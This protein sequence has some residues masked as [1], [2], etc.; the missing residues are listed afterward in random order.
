MQYPVRSAQRL[1]ALV[2]QLL[3]D[4]GHGM[5]MLFEAFWFMQFAFGKRSRYETAT[6]LYIT[7][8]KSL[9]VISVVALFTGMILA[10]QT[11]LELRRYGQEVYIGSAVAVSMIRE[12]GPFMT[13]LII[14]ASVGSAIAA[15][16]GTMS[17]SEE[18]SALEVMSI[19]PNRFL[20]MPRL[21]ALTVMMPILTVYTNILGILGGAVVG[22]TQLGVSFDAYVGN[23]TEFATNKDLYV[24]L[25]KAL[26][27]GIII[28]TVSCHQGF[29]T[30]EGAVGVGKA[31]RRS[32]IISFLV[33]L[34]VG[35]MVT[36]LF[37]I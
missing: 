10:L 37:Y 18:I 5:F 1:G 20:V 3:H 21:V 14:A 36:R 23:A 28:T 33:I 16:L 11:G 4:T 26:L 29:M 31:T 30:T 15:Q 6:Q 9:A 34:V 7:G 8:I 13:G 32:V 12:M 17:V 19:N 25:F 35:Y 2:L 27:F 24:G 22:A